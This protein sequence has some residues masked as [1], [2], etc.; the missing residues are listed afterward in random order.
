MWQSVNVHKMAEKTE[1]EATLL[2]QEEDKANWTRYKEIACNGNDKSKKNEMADPVV[3][4][5]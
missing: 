2:S 5:V 4:A 1:T 3:R